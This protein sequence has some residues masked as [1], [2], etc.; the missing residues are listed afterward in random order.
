[1]KDA[2]LEF[3][4]VRHGTLPRCLTI[5]AVTSKATKPVYFLR[6]LLEEQRDEI[7][8][9]S[10]IVECKCDLCDVGSEFARTNEH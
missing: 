9:L 3:L 2:L 1:V 5:F 8:R 10:M 6:L 7:G 4:C